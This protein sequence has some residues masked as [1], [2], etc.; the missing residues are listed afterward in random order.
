MNGIRNKTIILNLPG[1]PRGACENLEF[2]IDTLVHGLEILK[3]NTFE[4]ARK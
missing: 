3:G 4:C 1:S 2:V